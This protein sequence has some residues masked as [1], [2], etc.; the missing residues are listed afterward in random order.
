V[1]IDLYSTHIFI[2]DLGISYEAN[3]L[4]KRIIINGGLRKTLLVQIPIIII[5]GLLDSE[6][7]FLLYWGLWFGIARGLVGLRN[8]QVINRYRIMGVDRFREQDLQLKSLLQNS[9]AGQRIRTVLLPATILALCFV[10]MLFIED[11]TANS[12]IFALASFYS[13]EIWYGRPRAIRKT[14]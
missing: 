1:F 12:I 11:M 2:R 3:P 8:F 14:T 4:M 6:Y 5:L 7:S 13:A 9:S 10:A